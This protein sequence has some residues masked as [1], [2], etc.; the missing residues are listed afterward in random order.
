[1]LEKIL[2]LDS[3]RKLTKKEQNFVFGGATCTCGGTGTVTQQPS[4]AACWKF[5]DNDRKEQG[6]VPAD[7]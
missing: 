6:L 5:C 1:M 4:A 3:V 2:E 7:E